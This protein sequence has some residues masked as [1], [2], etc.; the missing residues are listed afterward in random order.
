MWDGQPLANGTFEE[1]NPRIYYGVDW[2][3]SSTPG[4]SGGA[5]GVTGINVNS[6]AWFPFTGDSVTWQAWASTNADLAE[7]RIDGVSRGAFNLYSLTAGPRAFSFTGLGSG[8]HVLEIRQYR[9]PVTVDA[10]ITPAIGPNY[11]SPT[12]AAIVRYEEDHP[13]MR[14]DGYP[15]RLVPQ[16]WALHASGSTWQRSGGRLFMC[17]T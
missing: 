2:G 6:T 5:Y 11:T 14:Y 13:A 8:A 15:Y 7:L 1:D 9:R 12:P 10:F 16:S 3:R 4:A 17:S